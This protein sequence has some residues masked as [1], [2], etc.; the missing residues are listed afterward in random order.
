MAERSP[1]RKLL[2]IGMVTAGAVGMY[3]LVI[4]PWLM[5]RGATDEECFRPL[6]GDALVPEPQWSF[7]H[8]ITIH[9]S[10]AEIWPWLAQWGY[11][12]GGFYSYDWIDQA[13]G[14]KGIVSASKILVEFQDLKVGDKVPVAPG[15][16]GF[17]VEKIEDCRYIVLKNRLDLKTMKPYDP[18]GPKPEEYLNLSWLWYLDPVAEDRTRL[19]SRCRMDLRARMTPANFFFLGEPLQPGS[20]I[21]DW[22]MLNGIKCR[23]E[24]SCLTVNDQ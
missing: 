23:A 4:K 20:A 5:R 14:A 12:R 2:H 8:G 24:G 13:L 17:V 21:M 18:R 1:F 11:G 19:I 9:A 15:G 6:P 7:T 3:A 22:G 10:P 16:E